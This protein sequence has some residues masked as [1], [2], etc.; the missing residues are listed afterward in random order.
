MAVMESWWIAPDIP[1]RRIEQ[2]MPTEIVIDEHIFC[3]FYC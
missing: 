2:Q 3:I 1:G